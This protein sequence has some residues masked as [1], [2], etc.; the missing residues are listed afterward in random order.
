MPSKKRKEILNAGH[1]KQGDSIEEILACGPNQK[2]EYRIYLEVRWKCRK[3][4]FQPNNSV[5]SSEEISRYDPDA[6]L[7]YY[8]K[9]IKFT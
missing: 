8:E 3:D 5:L 9:L 7:D 2:D 6:V 4:G 1:F